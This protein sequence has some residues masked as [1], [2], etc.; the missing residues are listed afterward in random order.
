MA[1]G[2]HNSYAMRYGLPGLL[3]VEPVNSATAPI[4]DDA[5]RK[6]AAALRAAR[7]GE[8]WRGFHV[9]RCGAQS[10]NTDLI[11]EGRFVTNSLAVHYLALHRGEVPADEIRDVL[12]LACEGVDPGEQEITGRQPKAERDRLLA[13][14]RSRRTPR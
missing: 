12:T 5:T 2:R 11:V 1:T 14:I 13:Q 3:F 10:D 9:C 4:I 7:H 6:M 8:S